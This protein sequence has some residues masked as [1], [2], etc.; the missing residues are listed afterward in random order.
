MVGRH[1][2]YVR[3]HGIYQQLFVIR[4][5]LHLDTG[6]V[7]Y[8]YGIVMFGSVLRIRICMFWASRIRIC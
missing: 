6:M 5:V 4:V 2:Y 8:R 1:G 7:R 3:Y